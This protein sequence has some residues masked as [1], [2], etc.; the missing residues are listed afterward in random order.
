MSSDVVEQVE[1]LMVKTDRG[2][3]TPDELFQEAGDAL[4]R[5]A[6][7]RDTRLCEAVARLALSPDLPAEHVV[8][9][10]RST[11]LWT[12]LDW[13]RAETGE[14][15]LD[16]AR[17]ALLARV[18]DDVADADPVT[19]AT[20]VGG[21]PSVWCPPV[22]IDRAME[23]DLGPEARATANAALLRTVVDHRGTEYA[24]R[25]LVEPFLDTATRHGVDL[26]LSAHEHVGWRAHR[27]PR[28]RRALRAYLLASVE[29]D[30]PG[31]VPL[32]TRLSI[33][34]DDAAAVE[35]VHRV[36]RTDPAAWREDASVLAFVLWVGGRRDAAGRVL[37][38]FDAHACSGG[39]ACVARHS[40]ADYLRMSS[41]VVPPQVVAS[42]RGAQEYRTGIASVGALV[43]RLALMRRDA[44]AEVG[45]AEQARLSGVAVLRYHGYREY[46]L[47]LQAADLEFDV[48]LVDRVAVTPDELFAT[49]VAVDACPP[50][51]DDGF[52]RLVEGVV[53]YSRPSSA[54][55][56][57]NGR[58]TASSTGA[59]ISAKGVS[60]SNPP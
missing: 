9:L 45:D 3:L 20:L 60:S 44:C 7:V 33:D 2:M 26:A 13:G 36:T 8:P 41:G 51:P 43:G 52:P 11:F 15:V 23:S 17:R 48:R 59:P 57:S 56:T 24:F 46:D 50:T 38:E 40:L 54:A 39:W 12:R 25:H 5:A 31:A 47:H 29:G 16:A 19:V 35:V 49:R 53:L 1:S 32:A 58:R 42:T 22:W 28:A 10:A 30:E 27:V 14:E 21:F 6:D 55:T 34:L 37:E 18:E 4:A